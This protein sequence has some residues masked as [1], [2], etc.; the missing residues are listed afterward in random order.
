M[1]ARAFIAQGRSNRLER[2]GSSGS[3]PPLTPGSILTRPR[4]AEKKALYIRECSSKMGPNVA[5]SRLGA[6]HVARVIIARMAKSEAPHVLIVASRAGDAR[7]WAEL[8]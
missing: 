3:P 1:C 5:L 4:V 8:L 6:G 7:R 2:S